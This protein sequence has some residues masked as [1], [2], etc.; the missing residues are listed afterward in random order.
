MD[1]ICDFRTYTGV[2]KSMIGK[3][4]LREVDVRDQHNATLLYN[5]TSSIGFFSFNG[6]CAGVDAMFVK[7]GY[8]IRNFTITNSTSYLE[9]SLSRRGKSVHFSYRDISS[10][11]STCKNANSAVYIKCQEL[12]VPL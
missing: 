4:R 11:C 2:V 1:C 10:L 7:P 3:T 5:V 8:F 6:D 9:I 12:I